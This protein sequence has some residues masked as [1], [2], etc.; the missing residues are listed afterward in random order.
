ML[1]IKELKKFKKKS[2]YLLIIYN[3]QPIWH[4]II[5]N[6]PQKMFRY[7]LHPDPLLI[8]L[9]IRKSKFG[10]RGSGSEKNNYGSA[11]LAGA[12]RTDMQ[13]GKSCKSSSLFFSGTNWEHLLGWS[14]TI[15]FCTGTSCRTPNRTALLPQIACALKHPFSVKKW[16]KNLTDNQNFSLKNNNYLV[17]VGSDPSH[18]QTPDLDPVQ[19]QKQDMDLV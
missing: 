4:H 15:L 3:L 12:Q 6:G 18:N 19:L 11:T 2:Y 5:F 9:W 13:S 10:I 17:E 16:M 14:F 8:G 1:F 7:D